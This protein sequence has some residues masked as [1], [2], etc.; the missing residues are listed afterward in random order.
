MHKVISSGS[1]HK[2][3]KGGY[4]NVTYSWNRIRFCVTCC[5]VHPFNYNRSFLYRLWLL[6]KSYFFMNE[7]RRTHPSALFN[8]L[9]LHVLYS[10][11]DQIPLL[12]GD[13][14]KSFKLKSLCHQIKFTKEEGYSATEILTLMIMFPLMLL[15]RVHA[16]YRSQYKNVTVMKKD[17]IYQMKNNGKMPWRSLL[18]GVAKRFQQLVNPQKEVSAHSAFIIDDTIDRRVGKKIGNVSWVHDHVENK[19]G[20]KV[21]FKNLTL[22]FFDEKSFNPLDFSLH[23][24]CECQEKSRPLVPIK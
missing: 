22:G 24:E 7:S 10:F 21:G 14:M 18:L 3:F 5:V 8:S 20:S 15:N 17:A 23:M 2:E 1:I 11:S 16:L 4:F 9:K 6:I 12:L 19:K 13:V